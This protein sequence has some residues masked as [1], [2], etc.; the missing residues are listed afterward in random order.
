MF[1][2]IF[3]AKAERKNAH[4]IYYSLVTRAR[5]PAFYT[6]M[7][8]ADT[9]EGRFDLIL[10]HLF[11]VDKRLEAEGQAYVRL[12]RYVQETM[13]SDMDRSFREL[14]VGDMSV[15][16]EMKKV[17]AAWLGRRSV[18]E[19]ATKEDAEPSVLLAAIEKNI[20]RGENSTGAAALVGY[21]RS[22]IAELASISLDEP[23]NCELFA[24]GESHE[25]T[26]I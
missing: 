10:L 11:M 13:I 15:G 7:G 19:M 14:G 18:Y 3:S 16:K 23:R 6:D 9:I 22:T 8:V 25:Q 2:T 12:R 21:V 20:F 1:A 17:G 26:S 5:Q 4:A 24:E